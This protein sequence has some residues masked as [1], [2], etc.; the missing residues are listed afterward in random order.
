[1][2]Q[3]LDSVNESIVKMTW[4]TPADDAAKALART[5]AKQI[6]AV[7][8]GTGQHVCD[9]CGETTEVEA[10]AT[11]ITKALYLGPHLLNALRSL[12]GSPDG[13]AALDVTEKVEGALSGIRRKRSSPS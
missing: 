8:E 10:D 1:M 13:R 4:L 9:H 7:I 6:D 5:Y 3:L 12:G 2:G 11:Q